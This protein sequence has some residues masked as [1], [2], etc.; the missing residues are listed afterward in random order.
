[1]PLGMGMS[2]PMP[3]LMPA[4]GGLPAP[5]FNPSMGMLPLDSRPPP[6]GRMSPTERGGRSSD[7]RS[8]SPE[9][10]RP[11]RSTHRTDSYRDHS[12]TSRSE[13]R[14]PSPVRRGLSPTRSERGGY[15][16][17]NT[18]DY[19][20]YSHRD[21]RDRYYSR[22]L[23]PDR[24]SYRRGSQDSSRHEDRDRDRERERERQPAPGARSLDY[25]KQTT[26]GP[27]TSSPMD[28]TG[29]RTYGV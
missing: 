7:C 14:G 21:S 12:P 3:G 17:R 10:D 27:K 26:P 28:P 16:D 29:G 22:D 11:Y 19:Q 13:R 20:D 18:R 4:M 23:S 15:R 1:M 6:I 2:M 8:P 5:I 9:Y 25:L 24:Y